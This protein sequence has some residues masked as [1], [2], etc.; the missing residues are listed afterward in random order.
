MQKERGEYKDKEQCERGVTVVVKIHTHT[1]THITQFTN[2]ASSYNHPHTFNL[3]PSSFYPP[4][5]LPHTFDLFFFLSHTT[6]SQIPKR[7]GHQYEYHCQRFGPF[8]FIYALS[9]GWAIQ[10]I[11][12][13]RYHQIIH[14]FLLLLSVFLIYPP[15]FQYHLGHLLFQPTPTYS[16]VNHSFQQTL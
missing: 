12:V 14:Q 10:L 5:T 16:L 1:H 4:Y 13:V 2:V 3:S 11:L 6:Y 9:N 15:M 7:R 8:Q